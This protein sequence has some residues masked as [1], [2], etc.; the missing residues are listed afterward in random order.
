MYSLKTIGA[1]LLAVCLL[2]G[3][4]QAQTLPHPEA[5]NLLEAENK[6]GYAAGALE[7][8]ADKCP[9]RTENACTRDMAVAQARLAMA[10]AEYTA[11]RTAELVAKQQAVPK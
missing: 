1:T 10:A 8:A 3:N 7:A 2:A 5:K 4:A 6:M 9:S 11:W